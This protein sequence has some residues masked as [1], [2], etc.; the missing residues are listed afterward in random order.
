[1]AAHGFDI[2]K[3]RKSMNDKQTIE[4]YELLRFQTIELEQM[5]RLLKAVIHALSD[6]SQ[7][8]FQEDVRTALEDFEKKTASFQHFEQQIRAIDERV[9]RLRENAG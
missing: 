2:Q 8:A 1:M 7:G 5:Y 6:Q 9:R 3:E 4:I